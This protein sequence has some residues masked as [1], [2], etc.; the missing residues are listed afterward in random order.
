MSAGSELWV[1]VDLIAK[2]LLTIYNPHLILWEKTI[3]FEVLGPLTL[4]TPV[5]IQTQRDITS[6]SC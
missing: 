5:S 4:L 3:I 1:E 2:G 6:W